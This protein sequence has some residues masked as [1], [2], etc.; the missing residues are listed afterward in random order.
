PSVCE[1]TTFIVSGNSSTSPPRGSPLDLYRLD[2][3]VE[4]PRRG[5]LLAAP[6]AR[7]LEPAE[8]RVR[9][10]ARRVAV[11]PDHPDLDPADVV[12]RRTDVS[13]EERRTEPVARAVGEFDGFVEV[14]YDERGQDGT[15]DLVLGQ[16][17]VGR[18][19][20]NERRL[21]EVAPREARIRRR[22]AAPHH[23]APRV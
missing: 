6:R 22:A 10:D 21:D 23:L 19:V 1:S 15:E 3:R 7:R 8:R 11:D 2:L 20:T 17:R 14:L 5:A 4:L 16:A 12:E 13:G 9:I 18:D